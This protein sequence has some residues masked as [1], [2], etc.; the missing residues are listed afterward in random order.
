MELTAEGKRLVDEAIGAHVANEREM[1]S[2]LNNR[3]RA[4]LARIT[5][6][7]IEHLE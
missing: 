4:D 1:L 7:L 2:V 5:R 6:K 3:D